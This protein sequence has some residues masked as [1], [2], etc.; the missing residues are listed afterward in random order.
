MK[1]VRWLSLLGVGLFLLISVGLLT[2]AADA[3]TIH[4]LLVIMDADASIGPSV[5][6][7]MKKVENLLRD[8]NTKRVCRVEK[9]VLRSQVDTANA[10]AIKRWL[11]NVRPGSDD[12]VFV[13]FSGHGG[14]L[15]NA[16]KTFISLQG[17]TL[18]RDELVRDMESA[19]NCRLKILITDACSS[20]VRRES[21]PTLNPT[22]E[23]ALRDLFVRHKGFL[24]LS[25]A[26]EGEYAWGTSPNPQGR[27]GG[28]FFTRS[29][30]NT[31]YEYPD[32]DGNGFVSWQEVFDATKRKTMA[33]F[34][35]AYPHF[36]A[37][38]KADFRERGIT[39]QTPKYYALPERV[40]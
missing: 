40:R 21:P 3:Q 36:S 13:Y 37:S 20:E 26:T 12:V 17:S 35:A 32:P 33:L 24:H 27:G 11:K 30:I 15:P 31:I 25:A 23:S 34:E 28:G 22:L 38:M 39:S 29:L 1:P 16:N 10:D 7:D 9:T 4:S 18:Y 19:R 6:A 14:M 2:P 8:I 5:A